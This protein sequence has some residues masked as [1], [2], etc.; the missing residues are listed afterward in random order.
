MRNAVHRCVY[1][2]EVRVHLPQMKN[3]V[4]TEKQRK[5]FSITAI[6][7]FVLFSAVVFWFVGKPMLEFISEPE[8]FRDWVSGQGLWGRVAFVGMV[9]LQIV[10]ALIPGEPLEIGAG[11]A[12]G[13]WEG[14]L[15]CL[16]GALIGS[17]LVFLFVR[18]FGVKVVH[19]FF[20][21]EKIQSLKFLQNSKKLNM[22]TFIVF[23]IP[24]TPKDILCYFMGLTKM[25]LSTW[26]SITAVARIPS[27]V[28]STIGG[29]ALGLKQYQFGIIFLLATFLV[30]GCGILAYRQI[31]K[32][33][34]GDDGNG[35]N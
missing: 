22:L 12:F 10:I 16:I 14:T 4:F 25:K 18:Y 34:K 19:V 13:V 29:N 9:V 11:Y 1:N 17:T 7:I 24:G 3:K 21:E 8:K 28:T 6:S 5:L 23:S 26:V 35:I 2:T 30:S 15:L 27:I 20:P 31:C 33:Q 32:S